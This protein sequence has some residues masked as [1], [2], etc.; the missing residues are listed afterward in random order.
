[1]KK[2]IRGYH[3]TVKANVSSII[4]DGFRIEK[5]SFLTSS[6]QKVPGDLG[7]GVYAF[8][9]NPQNAEKFAEKFSEDAAV[10]KLS[11]EVEEEYYLDMDEENNASLV[12]DIYNSKVFKYLEERYERTNK[13]AKN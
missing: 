3:G 10:L 5:Y 1:M 8:K 2:N 9:D 7:A 11:L 6:L 4:R 13:S 12:L